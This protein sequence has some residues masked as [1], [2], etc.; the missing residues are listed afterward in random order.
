MLTKREQ[1]TALTSSSSQH[2]SG[3]FIV[4]GDI[5]HQVSSVDGPASQTHSRKLSCAGCFQ[6]TSEYFVFFRCLVSLDVLSGAQDGSSQRCGLVRC[7]MQ[8]IKDH[9]LQIGLHF[10]HLSKDHPSLPLDL[11]FSQ[12]AVLD[13]V[14]QNLHSFDTERY[15]IV[16]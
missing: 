2:Y 14:S 12:R 10:L 11:R 1:K 4:S 5:L 16:L 13:D 6:Q 15:F 7:S 8:I 9:L 3:S